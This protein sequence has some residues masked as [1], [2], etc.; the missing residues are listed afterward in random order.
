MRMLYWSQSGDRL[1]GFP[2]VK[3]CAIFHKGSD[4]TRRTRNK[5]EIY[6]LF[7]SGLLQQNTTKLTNYPM[8]LDLI[9]F[10]AHPDDTELGCSGT[11]ASLAQAGKK[12]GV[13]DLTRGEMGSRGTMEKREQEAAKSSALIGL[14]VRKNLGLP[15]TEIQN[16]RAFQ[17]PIIREIRRYRPR[18][19]ILPPFEDRHPDHGMAARLVSD[20]VF[21]SG[22]LKIQTQSEDGMD[23]QP[24]RPPH[25]LTYML[26]TP[27]EPDIVFD[28]SDTMEVKKQAVRAFDS[29]FDVADPGDEPV[30]YI[31]DPAFFETLIARARRYGYRCGFEFGEPFRYSGRPIPVQ[32]FDLLADS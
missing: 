8:K 32:S 18:I 3:I 7:V 17:I 24:Y 28:I 22:L 19:V 14:K 10:G 4:H 12:I 15:D 29:Q 2:T 30:T 31:S 6:V 27:F 21:Y 25:V 9:A 5:W 23:Q 16:H 20:A 1:A 13:I 26:D 11:L